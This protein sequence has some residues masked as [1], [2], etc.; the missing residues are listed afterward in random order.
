MAAVLKVVD[1]Q[2]GQ[3]ASGGF[4]LRLASER[5]TAREL[6]Q[7]RVAEEIA[8]V[9]DKRVKTRS[10]HDRARSFLIRFDASPV[11]AKL[12]RPKRAT[13]P[14]RLDETA[15]IEAAIEGFEAKAYVM[16]FDDRQVE[17]LDDELT[18]L[19]NSEVV[20]LRMIP[21]VGG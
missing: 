21:L 3:S 10:A 16:L 13:P 7:R 12:N 2:L 20:F 14:A 8:L 17:D 5:L 15:E 18:V 4:E 6:I 11:E 1:K 19:P 9:N